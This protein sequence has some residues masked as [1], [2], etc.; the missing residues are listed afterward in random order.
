MVQLVIPKNRHIQSKAETFN[1]EGHNSLFRHFLA[2][3]TKCY[4]KSKSMLRYSI[5]LL[6]VKWNDGIEAILN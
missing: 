6:M 1:V 5:I 3:L 2:R 4:S